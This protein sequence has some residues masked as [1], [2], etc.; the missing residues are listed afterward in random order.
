MKEPRKPLV[1]G[2]WAGDPKGRPEDPLRC[3]EA[4]YNH[5]S[6]RRFQ[7]RSKRGKGPDG[8]YCGLHDPEKVKARADKTA[9]KYAKESE[10]YE[11][12]WDDARVGGWLRESD[13]DRYAAI[14]KGARP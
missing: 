6:R 7:C 13:P 11:R 5:H 4:V 9:A 12:H 10:L 2:V 1:Y 8:L 14:L 3:I